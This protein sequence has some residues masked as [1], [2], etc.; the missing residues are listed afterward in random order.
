[1]NKTEQK[2]RM[3]PYVVVK[4]NHTEKYVV[5]ICS[6]SMD[7]CREKKAYFDGI[8]QAYNYMHERLMEKHDKVEYKIMDGNEYDNMRDIEVRGGKEIYEQMFPEKAA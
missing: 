1:M 3:Y 6:G 2:K 7:E 8:H 5:V 4:V